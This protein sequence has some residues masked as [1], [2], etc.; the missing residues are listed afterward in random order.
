MK[1][2]EIEEKNDNAEKMGYVEFLRTTEQLATSKTYNA[3]HLNNLLKKR[4]Q[5]SVLGNSKSLPQ[6][7]PKENE[8]KNTSSNDKISSDITCTVNEAVSN[9]QWSPDKKRDFTD[10]SEL[11][12]PSTI[13]T[14]PSILRQPKRW[15]KK[16]YYSLDSSPKA[17]DDSTTIQS[18]L[19]Q[20][21]TISSHLV[22]STIANK[23][24]KRANNY[25][26]NTESSPKSKR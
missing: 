26:D 24:C 19:L 10:I 12:G 4:E 14:L 13:S 25:Q 1:K 6:I 2:D 8:S 18:D 20:M 17:L 16:A 3:Q 9:I 23:H 21:P 7:K 5:L 15:Q 11:A 22:E